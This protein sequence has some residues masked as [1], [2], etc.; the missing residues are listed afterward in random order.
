MGRDFKTDRGNSE[1]N[2]YKNCWL[3][4]FYL[5]GVTGI[6]EQYYIFYRVMPLY[7]FPKSKSHSTDVFFNICK[8][9]Q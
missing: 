6:H 1:C 2:I 4:V 3:N 8:N 9:I 5:F 7:F